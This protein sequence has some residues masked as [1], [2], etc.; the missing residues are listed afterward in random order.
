M[1]HPQKRLPAYGLFLSLGAFITL[2]VMLASPSDPKNAVFLGYSL[3]RILLAAGILIPGAA[4][5]YLTLR[6][7]RQPEHSQRLWLDV[8]ARG[9]IS[10][11][12]FFLSL[13]AFFTG[14]ILLF[15]PSYRLGALAGY[16]QRLAPII[17]WLAVSGAVTSAIL[18]IERRNESTNPKD[19]TR[20]ILRVALIFFGVFVLMG[21]LV[22]FTGI[23]IDYPA[24]YW[25]GAGVPVL[26]LQVLFCLLIGAV[27]L[28]IEGKTRFLDKRGIDVVIFII[29]WLMAAWLWSR[30]PLHPNYFMPDTADNVIYPYSDGATFD[31][32]AQYLLI[33]QGLFNGQFFERSL[34]S[35]FLAYLHMAL[36]Q[37]F[38]NLMTAQAALFGVLPAV[39]YLIGV[40]LHSRPFGITAG[41]LIALR[42][43]NA[44]IAA[45]W[46]DTASPKMMLTDFPAA[47]LIS[48]FLLLLLKW[49]RDPSRLGLLG[50]MGA[51]FGF[52][53]MVRTHAISLLPAALIFLPFA[54]KIRWKGFVLT[55]L[56]I[57]LGLFAVTLP[58]EIRNQ[59]KGIPM[60]SS[61]YSRL[62]V[63]L[64]HRY[65]LDADAYMPSQISSRASESARGFSRQRTL[66]SSTEPFCDSAP[67]SIT[68]HLV[69]N[70]VTSLVSLPSSLTFDD[71]WNTVKA[72]TPYWKKSW[73]EGQIGAGGALMIVFNLAMIALGLGSIWGRV[74]ILS[75][76]PVFL[77]IAYLLANSAGF[78]SGGR[79]IAP[80][81]WIV[82]LF[83]SA[84]GLQLVTW[85]LRAAGFLKSSEQSRLQG[86][87][88][89]IISKTAYIKLLLTFLFILVVGSLLPL[90]EAFAKP[91]YQAREPG[92]ILVI[93]EE[94]GLLQQTGFSRQELTAFLAQ[95]NAMIS[96][97]RAL[98]P[99]YY[100]T[101][102]GEPDRST[103]YR[104]LDYQR[105]VLTLIGPDNPMAEGVVIPGDPPPFSFH[106]ED[107][108]AIGCWNTN[109]YAPYIDSVAVF[110]LSGE[111]YVYTRSPSAPLQCPLPEPR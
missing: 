72:D 63:I 48:L 110:V 87:L 25:Y 3:E 97:G 69:H 90:S 29:L 58:W 49:I 99:R 94:S 92:E 86:T 40:E 22:A 57:A 85:V 35:I 88:F 43:M 111:G 91:R 34:Y 26:G 98:Y 68:N 52:A 39:V 27:F 109:Y 42:G 83:Y 66:Q 33:G 19:S 7:F 11:S 45:K 103:Y 101:G 65:G 16:V 75:L 32:G 18:L 44:V 76:L 79:Y 60:Y 30:E 10:D 14:W 36:G 64:R 1:L 61:Y 108:I 17:G 104:F 106:A 80:V 5:L 74:R 37:D 46:I 96:E 4:L 12:I 89:P 82:C 81:D 55:G 105:L 62:M 41:A 8:S 51:V 9:W 28:W 93:L 78:T 15:M 21:G 70:V 47:I 77:F 56:L 31:Q 73:S 95:P 23:G 102:E 50:W 6:L 24:D 71:L 84:G 2:V 54:M 59:S 67:C 107:V 13:A 20:I 100:R 38:E 53:L